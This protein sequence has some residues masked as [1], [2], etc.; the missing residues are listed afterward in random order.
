M[1]VG[2]VIGLAFLRHS[3][4]ILIRVGVTTIMCETRLLAK[5]RRE[6]HPNRE[7]YQF[8][9]VDTGVC[10]RFRNPE[11]VETE[12]T[13]SHCVLHDRPHARRAIERKT[14]HSSRAASCL[15]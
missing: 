8:D 14:D 6:Q 15:T 1:C 2:Q 11:R 10:L 9:I 3:L 12:Y 4:S 5:Q 7:R 13:F